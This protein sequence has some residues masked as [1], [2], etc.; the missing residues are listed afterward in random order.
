MPLT[1]TST[2]LTPPTDAVVAL[3][4]VSHFFTQGGT[5]RQILFDLNADVWPGELVMVM[6]P[7]GSGKT[8][9]L[10]LIGALR[11][12]THGSVS[13]LGSELYGASGFTRT[14][15]RRKIGFIFQQHNLLESLTVRQNVQMGIGMTGLPTQETQRRAERIL[16]QVGLEEYM[17]V[18]PSTLSGGQRQRLAVSRA[19]VREPR[20]LLA[21]E[22]TS[23]LDG[24]TGREVVE[25]LR[26]LARQQGCAVL[27]VTHDNRV[28][29]VADR[30]MY[31]EDGRLSSF[32]AV[33][34]P[35]AAH[36]LTAL[37]SVAE[38]REV[39]SLLNRM[40]DGEFIDLLR[41]LA[42]ES[43]QFLNVLDLGNRSEARRVFEEIARAVVGH[44]ASQFGASE[45]LIWMQEGQGGVR[46]LIGP[47]SRGDDDLSA[48][49]ACVQTGLVQQQ[50]D[51]LYLPLYGRDMQTVGAA[52]I[53][54]EAQEAAVHLFRDFARPLG[55]LAEVCARLES[56]V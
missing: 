12:V 22:P 7:S 43:E 26:T 46:L 29:E 33:T 13:V 21:D 41:T 4:G 35:H 28:L 20:L 44:M 19:L 14:E 27:M 9:M 32:A 25:L 45:V 34:S 56:D 55:L 15:I 31:L 1:L 48:V 16:G 37:R 39:G 24:Q 5:L 49:R 38:Q 42:A 23:A 51:R 17:H 53:R 50:R 54:A 11:N 3:R 47:A 6:G 2:S 18:Y 40:Q 36:L 8:T 10:N 30:L 52:E